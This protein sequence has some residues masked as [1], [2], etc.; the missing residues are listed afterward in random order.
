MTLPHPH[1]QKSSNVPIQLLSLKKVAEKLDVSV[2]SLRRLIDSSELLAHKIG[3]QIRISTLDLHAFVS[4]SR[5]EDE[6]L[7]KPAQH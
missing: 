1:V 5:L 2:S 6:D 7:G 3:G 4:A